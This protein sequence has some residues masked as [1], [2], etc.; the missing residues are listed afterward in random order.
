MADRNDDITKKSFICSICDEDTENENGFCDGCRDDELEHGATIIQYGT[1]GKRIFRVSEHFA[2][3]PTNDDVDDVDAIF[4]RPAYV[5]T[6]GWR[7]YWKIEP[8]DKTPEGLIL[9]KIAEGWITGHPDDTVSHKQPTIDLY[10]KLEGMT[11]WTFNLFWVMTPTSNV[12]STASDLYVIEPD[13]DVFEKWLKKELNLTI[14][15]LAEAF[16]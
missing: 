10:R 6:D 1:G 2:E 16:K 14:D 4:K 9:Q 15:Q 12:F 3:S 5:R 7:G 11:E 8:Q 13:R